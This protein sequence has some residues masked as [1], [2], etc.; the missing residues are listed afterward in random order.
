MYSANTVLPSLRHMA[1]STSD[2]PVMVSVATTTDA[3]T[4]RDAA[5]QT[6]PLIHLLRFISR[7]LFSSF[8]CLL[9]LR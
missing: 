7:S 9:I 1:V 8:P 5:C 4:A 6:A 2:A 3:T